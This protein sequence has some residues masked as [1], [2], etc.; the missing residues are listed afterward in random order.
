MTA[1][2]I[3]TSVE[4]MENISLFIPHVFP[5]FTQEYIFE[6]FGKIGNV[7]RVDLVPKHDLY[8]KVKYHSVYIHLEQWHF[9]D[10][11]VRK[12]YFDVLDKEARFYHDDPWY[13][14]VLPNTAKKHSPCERKPR[15]DLG[16]MH[17]VSSKR[18]REEHP[19]RDGKKISFSEVNEYVDPPMEEEQ[20]FFESNPPCYDEQDYAR[21]D[22]I[23]ALQ[24]TEEEQEGLH[25]LVSVDPEY[26]RA[27]EQENMALRFEV[28]QLRTAVINLDRMYQAEAA[29]LRAFSF[30]AVNAPVEAEGI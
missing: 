23:D 1:L 20:A 5:N 17:A 10:E 7:K 4:D 28:D 2:A 22:E 29:K 27:I 25:G 26:I 24:G 6:V 14:I 11:N 18:N 3:A 21:M 12:F 16:D 15:L 30:G 19:L 13:W 8:G 9:A